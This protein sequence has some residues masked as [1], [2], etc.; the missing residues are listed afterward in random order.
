MGGGSVRVEGGE[1]N[2]GNIGNLTRPTNFVPSAKYS[3]RIRVDPWETGLSNGTRK[4]LGIRWEE[5]K[6]NKE[7]KENKR[8]KMKKRREGMDEDGGSRKHGFA[9]LYV[10]TVEEYG[11]RE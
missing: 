5:G 11:T 1:I 10:S 6:E 3:P 8:N 7:N 2:N 4:A 9:L